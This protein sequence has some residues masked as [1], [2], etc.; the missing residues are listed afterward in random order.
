MKKE[1]EILEKL[2]KSQHCKLVDVNKDG[3]S[4]AF[5]APDN[6][7]RRSA[8]LPKPLEKMVSRDMFKFVA[9]CLTKVKV[10]PQ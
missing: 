9:D 2:F 8:T 6:K 5:L 4:I 7:T 1:K 3:T 10:K